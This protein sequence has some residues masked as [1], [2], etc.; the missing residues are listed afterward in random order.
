MSL[1]IVKETNGCSKLY[2]H[3]F[4][5]IFKIKK[6]LCRREIFIR[7]FLLQ[8]IQ[9]SFLF[10]RRLALLSAAKM[11]CIVFKMGI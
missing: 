7:S 8:I 10:Q 2:I 3:S 4:R 5:E 9:N 11:K 1:N 6:L